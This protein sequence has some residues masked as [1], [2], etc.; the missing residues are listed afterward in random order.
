MKKFAC[1]FALVLVAMVG[2]FAE[3]S[4]TVPLTVLIT[5]PHD[6]YTLSIEYTEL[7]GEARFLYT[8]NRYIYDEDEAIKIVRERITTF[9]KE[10]GFFRYSYMRPTITK[11]DYENNKT[12]FYSFVLFSE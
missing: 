8:T 6:T 2:V 5:E 10:K 7:L 9:T 12:Y 11:I 3:E 4:N 1:I